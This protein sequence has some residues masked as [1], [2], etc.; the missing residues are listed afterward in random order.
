MRI[1]S[2]L[3]RI[4]A[5]LGIMGMALFVYVANQ[6]KLTGD[7]EVTMEIAGQQITALPEQIIIAQIVMA[8]IGA[9]IAVLGVVTLVRKPKPAAQPQTPAQ[10]QAPEQPPV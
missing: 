4:L 6:D 10:P 5:G 7:A 3:I 2:G 9:L 8:V 1:L